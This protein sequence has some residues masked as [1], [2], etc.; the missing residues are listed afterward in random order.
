[1]AY[2]SVIAHRDMKEHFNFF[3]GPEGVKCIE[4]L[5]SIH[6]SLRLMESKFI[7]GSAGL[8]YSCPIL[9]Y[10]NDE[11][12]DSVELLSRKRKMTPEPS[13]FMTQEYRHWEFLGDHEEEFSSAEGNQQVY[14]ASLEGGETSLSAKKERKLPSYKRLSKLL[15]RESAQEVIH[16]LENSVASQRI[17]I[18]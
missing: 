10:M 1:M 4:L 14:T 17:S 9:S 8:H 15:V 5:M 16:D 12:E 18:L 6:A 3:P 13:T 7:E 2:Q 11:E